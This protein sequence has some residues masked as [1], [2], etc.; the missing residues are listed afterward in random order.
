MLIKKLGVMVLGALVLTTSA[1]A[2]EPEKNLQA[3]SPQTSTNKMPENTKQ[4]LAQKMQAKQQ[5]AK[6]KP[7][8]KTEAPAKEQ[9]A[10]GKPKVTAPAELQAVS[11]KPQP[12]KSRLTIRKVNL[13]GTPYVEAQHHKKHKKNQKN[14]VKVYEERAFYM[15][16]MLPRNYQE[17]SIFGEAK[18]TKAQAVAYLRNNNPQVK[19]SCSPEKLVDLYWEEALREGICPDL[20]FCQAIVETGFF[21]YGGDVIYKQNNFCGLGTTGG[22]VRGASF[23]TPQLGVR[24]HVQHLLA[25]SKTSKPKT[26]IV[27]PR[28]QIAHNLQ[29]S[30]GLINKWFGL[31]GTWAMGAE[32]CEKIMYHYAR[33]LVAKPLSVGNLQPTLRSEGHNLSMRQ[34][35]AQNKN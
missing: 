28:Y 8:P 10:P 5:L 35:L 2:N 25:Y 20:T 21:K 24:A 15:E 18:A 1:W 31:N 32:Y 34:R 14:T 27:D 12:P 11:A 33:M 9:V 17:I 13:D 6:L 3:P 7:A 22:G 30:R 4:Q 26:A 16:T 19:L 23:K 29:I